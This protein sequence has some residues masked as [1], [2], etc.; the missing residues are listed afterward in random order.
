MRFLTGLL[1]A[2]LVSACSAAN[3]EDETL[4]SEAVEAIVHRYIVE[5]PEVIEEA[6]IE[7]QR[8]A[9]A[10]EQADLV[11]GT[12]QFREAIYED[13]RDPVAGP[14]DAEL[15]IV[16]FFDYRCPYC[17]QTNDWMNDVLARHEGRVRIVFKELPLLGAASD[18]AARAAMAVWSL[19]PETYRDFHDALMQAGSPMNSERIDQIAAEQGIGREALRE[20]MAS[21]EIQTHLDSV[22]ELARSVGV[23][24]TPFFII[25][26]DVI[27]G[28]DINRLNAAVASALDG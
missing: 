16:E 3:G 13:P 26:D 28:A 25:G 8:R 17:I 9:R 6:L 20:A 19:S 21:P 7:L 15:T 1:A 5:N 10:R 23:S 4:D 18:E 24:G 22:Y 14:A 12:Q 27:P 2:C 11:A